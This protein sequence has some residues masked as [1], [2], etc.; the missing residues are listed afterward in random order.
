M[1]MRAS[2]KVLYDAL[3]KLGFTDLAQRAVNSEWNDYFGKGAMNIHHLISTL[4]DRKHDFP[5]KS[6]A[7]DEVIGRAMDGD[8][9]ATSAEADEWAASD[10]GRE[11]I[12]ALLK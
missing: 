6:A 1:T 12:G 7:I 10:E 2:D 4:R 9:D 3:L 5:S 11:T 8:F